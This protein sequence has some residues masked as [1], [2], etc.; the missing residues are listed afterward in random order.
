MRQNRFFYQLPQP[1]DLFNRQELQYALGATLYMPAMKTP[2]YADF[3]TAKLGG[4]MS[5]ILCLEDATGDS[6]VAEAEQFL[7]EQLKRI[8]F[9]KDQTG[10][11]LPLIFVR[12][13]NAEQIERIVTKLGKAARILKGFVFPKFTMSNGQ[14]YLEVVSKINLEQGT[15]FYGMPILESPE[16]VYVETR[17]EELMAIKGLLDS[18]YD[19]ILNVRLGA[20]DLS[21]IFGLRRRSDQTIYD[22]AVI[23]DC[24]AHFVNVFVRPDKGYVVSGPVWEFYG[25]NM[26]QGLIRE[27]LLDQ[28][29]GLFGKSIIHPRHIKLVQAL[30]AVSYEEY[31]DAHMILLGKENKVG[32]AASS[33]A[34]KMNE[35]KPHF[36]WAQKTMAK[37]KVYGVLH[38]QYNSQD[39]LKAN[40]CL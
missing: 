21:G 2:D 25:H 29:N 12:V 17:R 30:Y 9:V 36:R 7:V 35:M 15:K 24:I 28:A 39:L 26:T 5:I 4:L 20:T 19:L 23:R 31:S 14:S 22:I 8:W 13:R 10:V 11:S 16:I 18:F 38:E 3:A 34:N 32:V 40:Y 33:Y 37:A 6:Q 1:V 27:V